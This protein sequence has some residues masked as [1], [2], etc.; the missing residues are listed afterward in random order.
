[1]N[2]GPSR[3][4]APGWKQKLPDWIRE[5]RF[6]PG[7]GELLAALGNGEIWHMDARS[8]API[9]HFLA[10]KMGVLQMQWQ[11]KGKLLATSGEDGCARIWTSLAADACV[12]LPKQR[13]WVEQLAWSPT[14][15]A[16][17]IAA[18][19]KVSLWS[20]EGELLAECTE[21]SGTVLALAWHPSQDYLVV[22]HAK[23]ISIRHPDTLELSD[24]KESNSA[25]MSLFWSPNGD[26]LASGC[27]DT[28]VRFWRY[29]SFQDSEMPGYP[30]RP[31]AL[32]W[33]PKSWR[34]ATSGSETPILWDFTGAGPE[35]TE[36]DGFEGLSGTVTAL[37]FDFM[38]AI[39]A[40]ASDFGEVVLWDS[41]NGQMLSNDTRLSDRITGLLWRTD[42]R[43]LLVSSAKGELLSLRLP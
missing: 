6:V 17:A 25:V 16:L 43:Q 7:E 38:G 20:P 5:I 2:R 30:S 14:G 9:G 21:E 22:A 40:A 19:K 29:P 23:G 24:I 18:G 28:S 33:H 31:L 34:L 39:F 35:G 11:P 26:Y 12:T 4:I 8:G 15:K 42:S 10:H 32:A 41:R 37:Q 13:G 36:P 27:A 1:M 3:R